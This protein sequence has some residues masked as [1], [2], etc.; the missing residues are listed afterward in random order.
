MADSLPNSDAHTDATDLP[1]LTLAEVRNAFMLSS[2]WVPGV[3]RSSYGEL[4]DAVIA[5]V[6]R[7][8][9][10]AL[11]KDLDG[12]EPQHFG[13]HDL[14]PLDYNT[15]PEFGMDVAAWVARYRASEIR[16]TVPDDPGGLFS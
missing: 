5:S 9:L 2:V 1:E 4:F 11:A 12:A 16:P 3:P 13:N 8:T 10:E 7:E 14:D 6:R 15:G